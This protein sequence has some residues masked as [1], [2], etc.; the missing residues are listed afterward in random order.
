MCVGWLEQ[1]GM[2]ASVHC[3]DLHSGVPPTGPVSICCEWGPLR[4]LLRK[5]GVDAGSQLSAAWL[6]LA[7]RSLATP[8]RVQRHMRL[9]LCVQDPSTPGAQFLP[10]PSEFQPGDYTSSKRA[11]H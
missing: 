11:V 9:Y 5:Q 8:E 7:L 2:Q 4:A 10:L 3:A 6:S 1:R